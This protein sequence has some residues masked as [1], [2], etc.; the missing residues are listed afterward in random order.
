LLETVQHTLNTA[1]VSELMH[2]GGEETIHH[3]NKVAQGGYG[4][5]RVH[6]CPVHVLLAIPVGQLLGQK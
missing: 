6:H 4:G 1:V 2:H 3:V 5:T